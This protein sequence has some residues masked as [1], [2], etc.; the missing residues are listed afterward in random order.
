MISYVSLIWL[1]HPR[2]THPF[3]VFGRAPLVPADDCPLVLEVL[4]YTAADVD[5]D[6][7]RPADV[8]WDPDRVLGALWLRPPPTNPLPPEFFTSLR[9]DEALGE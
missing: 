2:H 9:E 3:L 6:P 8:D 5:W 4:P 1:P 7:D